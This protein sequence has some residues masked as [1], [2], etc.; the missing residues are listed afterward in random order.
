MNIFCRAFL[1]I[2]AWLL[3]WELKSKQLRLDGIKNQKIGYWRQK[4]RDATRRCADC[5]AGILWLYV[6]MSIAGLFYYYNTPL[7][8]PFAVATMVIN[9]WNWRTPRIHMP[10]RN[11]KKKT[12]AP[13]IVNDA[14]RAAIFNEWDGPDMDD[15]GWSDA[16][17]ED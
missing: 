15:P 5:F 7:V 4:W 3:G 1:I 16:R 2:G 6:P 17:K 13:R 10:R 11:H 12:G 9:G 8:F 14:R